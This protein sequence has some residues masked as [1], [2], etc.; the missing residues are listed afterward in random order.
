MIPRRPDPFLWFI[1][2]LGLALALG[3]LLASC[4][5][6][7]PRP[8]TAQDQSATASARAAT[9]IAASDTAAVDA[10]KASAK[11]QELERQAIAT[12]TPALIKAAADARVEAASAAAVAAAL[13]RVSTEASAA[14]DAKAKAAAIAAAED[15]KAQDAA[16]QH[17]RAWWIAALATGAAGLAAALLIGLSAPARWQFLPAAIAAGG[18]SLY[19]WAEWATWIAATFGLAIAVALIIGAIL[20]IRQVVKVEWPDAVDSLREAMPGA[21][22]AHDTASVSRQ[23]SIVKTVVDWL[24]GAHKKNLN[25][26]NHP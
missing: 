14:A 23:S 22:F 16:A 24:L 19:A 1:L 26:W 4:A 8:G 7:P 21:A 18:W 11:A 2:A 20:A 9:T 25:P 3:I 5:E 13:H 17:A 12:P 15:R 10:A 6:P